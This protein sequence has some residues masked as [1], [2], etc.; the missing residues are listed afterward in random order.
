MPKLKPHAL[1]I[2]KKKLS[3]FF[4]EKVQEA[5][6]LVEEKNKLN[7]SC[8]TELDNGVTAVGYGVSD[9]GRKYWLVKNSWGTEW[10]E[11]GYIRMQRAVPAA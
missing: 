11:E 10:G 2:F 1:L 8:G 6:S 4:A 9:D 7:G 3:H 5:T